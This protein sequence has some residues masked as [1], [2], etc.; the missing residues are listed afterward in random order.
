MVELIPGS[1]GAFEVIADGKTVF[2]KADTGRFPK[3]GEVVNKLKDK[4]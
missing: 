3:S 2:S 4:E 1:G